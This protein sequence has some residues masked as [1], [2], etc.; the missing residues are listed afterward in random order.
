MRGSPSATISQ[1]S[2]ATTSPSRNIWLANR[3]SPQVM[4]TSSGSDPG[5]LALQP[6]QR[7]AGTLVRPALLGP[8]GPVERLRVVGELLLQRGFTALAV[9]EPLEPERT[10]VE[11]VHRRE[12]GD[13]VPPHRRLLLG[14]RVAQ[15]AVD[16]VVGSVGRSDAVD[17]AHDPERAAEPRRV[18]LE[19]EHLRH[20]DVGVLGQR[21]HHPELGLEVGLEE[22]G[23]RLRRDAGDEVVD[24]RVRRRPSQ[25]AS[26]R[27]VSFE[28]PVLPGISRWSTVT[29]C[30]PATSPSQRCSCA[31]VWS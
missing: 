30:R 20:R 28:N 16:G 7:R 26:K 11:V 22:H 10:P 29:P 23:V 24:G 19:P 25:V 8:L 27:M 9:V 15:P 31:T 17:P 12:G 18:A 6:R 13:A 3:E 14:V 1:S 5:R 21:L 2:T 4:V